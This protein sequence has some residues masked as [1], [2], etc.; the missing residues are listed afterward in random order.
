[1]TPQ[2][3][4]VLAI[5]KRLNEAAEE[6]RAGRDSLRAALLALVDATDAQGRC[7][8]KVIDANNVV[9]ELFRADLRR[10][11]GDTDSNASSR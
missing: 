4:Q 6:V 2:R 3:Q 9:I 7:I 11:S 1:M 8:D 10:A 5:I